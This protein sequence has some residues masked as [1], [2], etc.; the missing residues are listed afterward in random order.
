[1]ANRG[2]D[3]YVSAT[4]A[5]HRLGVS[6]R[7]LRRYTQQGRLPDA[8][9]AG[10]RR[11]F[12]IG[13]L[14][15]ITSKPCAGNAIGYARVSSRRQQAEGDLDRQVGRLQEKQRDLL[16]FTDVASGLSD[17][18]AGLRK[19]LSECMKPGVDRLLVEHPDRLA[20]FGVGLIE[21]LLAGFGVQVIYT[22]Q[23][24]NESAESELVRDMLAIVTSFAGRLYGQ[25]S[26]KTKRLRATVAAETE[27]GDA[28]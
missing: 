27:C 5:A 20:R 2:P 21:H 10:G 11:I 9:S 16:V 22:G 6:T 25:R 1:M 13:D 7:T 19:A 28:A 18:R 17:R 14:D 4:A 3:D 8:R 12:R 24:E 26:V 15:A 23:P